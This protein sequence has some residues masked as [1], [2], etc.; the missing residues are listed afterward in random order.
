MNHRE[1]VELLPWYANATLGEEERRRVEAHLA[2]C[3]ECVKEAAS[4]KALRQTVL[5]SS[6][7]MPTLSPSGLTRVMAEIDDY[8]L[9][10][11]D[12]VKAPVRHI[13]HQ[14]AESLRAWWQTTPV[15]ARVLIAAQL[16]MLLAFGT[17]TV[18]RYHS[19]GT[20]YTT[21][22]G[23]RPDTSKTAVVIK[24][25]PTASEQEIR[26]TVSQVGGKIIDGPSALELY[27]VQLPIPPEHTTDVQ[28][29]LQ[30]MRKNSRVVQFAE[31]KQ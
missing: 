18:Y 3:E 25:S 28:A 17:L 2:Q 9:A 27:T 24:F 4:V 10:K 5:A 6:S 22:S 26:A 7:P 20:V 13:A 12:F 29:A 31:Q 16:V 1:I 23:P 30:S 8:E 11:Q 19:S 14:T 21:S 15:F